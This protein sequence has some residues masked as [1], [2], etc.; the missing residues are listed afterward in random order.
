M[1]QKKCN[2]RSGEISWTWKK[3]N[4]S[5]PKNCIICK[6]GQRTKTDDAREKTAK[7]NPIIIKKK[8]FLF[9]FLVCVCA[10]F[11]QE[12]GETKLTLTCIKKV[13][14][15]ERKKSCNITKFS[16]FSFFIFFI[17]NK[18]VARNGERKKMLSAAVC[19]VEAFIVVSS[20]H[21]VIY[22]RSGGGNGSSTVYRFLLEK[23]AILFSSW[24]WIRRNWLV[25][26]WKLTIYLVGP[27]SRRCHHL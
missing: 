7:H 12:G 25:A 9:G 5:K 4:L 18:V 19:R 15:N 20:S 2:C 27:Q 16:L 3:I 10:K 6:R 21:L 24:A 26:N 14:W 1:S 11:A 23:S 13:L 22:R 17:F 8:N